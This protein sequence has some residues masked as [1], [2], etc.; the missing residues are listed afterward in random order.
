MATVYHTPNAD[1]LAAIANDDSLII[2]RGSNN[3]TSNVDHS[4]IAG[5]VDISVGRGMTGDIGSSSAYF[6][7]AITGRIL[8]AAGGGTFYYTI[9]GS[10]TDACASF[11]N[12]SY[13]AVYV[14]GAGTMTKFDAQ[15]GHTV[16]GE[17]VDLTTFRNSGGHAV[18]EYDATAV[19]TLTQT[20]GYTLLRRPGPGSAA[21]WN[22]GGG[23]LDI[24]LKSEAGT[25]LTYTNVTFNVGDARLK[26]S[27]E[28]TIPAINLLHANS[29]LDLSQVPD[30]LTI[31][32]LAG[33]PMAIAKTGLV[34]GVNS[35][36]GK[37]ITITAIDTFGAKINQLAGDFQLQ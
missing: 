12:A 22:I 16:I 37:T 26:I 23:V 17:G 3:I 7:A 13:G 34:S 30:A 29:K 21:T 25:S 36:F 19:T 4:A 33:D 5:I 14:A 11:I 27:A 15:S 6:K 28:G 32:S 8:Y 18:L 24:G 10:G 31:T 1:T 9:D 20:A 2:T 35:V